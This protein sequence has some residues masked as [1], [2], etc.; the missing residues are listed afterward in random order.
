V[1][2]D[3]Q[4]EG[5]MTSNSH[6]RLALTVLIAV[7][8]A[9]AHIALATEPASGGGEAPAAVSVAPAMPNG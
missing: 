4:R 1:Q 3:F 7:I 2:I 6:L 9:W 5:C 8:S